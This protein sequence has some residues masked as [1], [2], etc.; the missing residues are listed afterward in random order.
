ML[1]N[2][3]GKVIP[4]IYKNILIYTI[5]IALL[6]T[7]INNV[8][9]SNNPVYNSFEPNN[10]TDMEIEYTSNINYDDIPPQLIINQLTQSNNNGNMTQQTMPNHIP[11]IFQVNN[12]YSIQS[13]NCYQSPMNIF[14]S[15]SQNNNK[16]TVKRKY[17]EIGQTNEFD[18]REVRRKICVVYDYTSNT[19]SETNEQKN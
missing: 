1:H 16:D 10:D 12:N 19:S 15:T 4:A 18:Q 5:T 3:K 8:F 11:N 14:N 7:P 6:G 17:K 9:S 13:N 2:F